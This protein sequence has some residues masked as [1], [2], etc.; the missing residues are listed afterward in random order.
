MLWSNSKSSRQLYEAFPPSTSTVTRRRWHCSHRHT[1]TYSSQ[2][3]TDVWN[4]QASKMQV[5]ANPFLVMLVVL[6]LVPPRPP[7]TAPPPL[8]SPASQDQRSPQT[9][10]YLS[11][12]LGQSLSLSW[13]A[14]LPEAKATSSRRLRDTSIGRSILQR[15]LMLETDDGSLLEVDKPYQTR[16]STPSFGSLCVR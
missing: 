15:S 12:M 8:I 14:F 3:S 7:K 1:A 10:E 5:K 2:Q 6:C 9:D 4:L 13:S 11:A 16:A